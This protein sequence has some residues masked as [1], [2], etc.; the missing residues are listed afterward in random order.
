VHGDTE[1][2]RSITVDQGTEFTSKALEED[3]VTFFA[4]ICG[5]GLD[6]VNWN[7]QE[8]S[9]QTLN[10]ATYDSAT[11]KRVKTDRRDAMLLARQSRAG[12]LVAVAMPDEREEARTP[13]F[14]W[15]EG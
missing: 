2:H 13:T 7:Y 8:P 5:G 9:N 14:S 6:L 4:H 11:E 3:D 12:D 10:E 15:I 1:I